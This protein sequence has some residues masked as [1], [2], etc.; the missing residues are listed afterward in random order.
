MYEDC[1]DD[2]TD[3]SEYDT[4]S[5]ANSE[6]RTQEV[7][8]AEVIG[9]WKR[10][11]ETRS[12]TNVGLVHEDDDL[13]A[14]ATMNCHQ[15]P[16]IETPDPS[17]MI[18]ATADTIRN[19][20]NASM[21][22]SSLLPH[23]TPPSPNPWASSHT[24]SASSLEDTT[25]STKRSSM[26][27]L[28][29]ISIDYIN[30]GKTF[31]E[32]SEVLTTLNKLLKKRSNYLT[33][34]TDSDGNKVGKVVCNG[35]G[36]MHL[37]DPIAVFSVYRKQMKLKSD[38]KRWRKFF[39]DSEYECC[40]TR[41]VYDN[42]SSSRIN[43]EEANCYESTLLNRVEHDYVSLKMSADEVDRIF[44]ASI[45][46]VSVYRQSL[47][48]FLRLPRP[49]GLKEWK[50][51]ASEI[52]DTL[53]K[54]KSGNSENCSYNLICKL[55]RQFHLI[56]CLPTIKASPFVPETQ[57]TIDHHRESIIISVRGTCQMLDAI[58]DV[59]ADVVPFLAHTVHGGH[60][61]AGFTASA[62]QLAKLVVPL[63][64]ESLLKCDVYSVL[65]TGHSMGGAVASLL[66]MLFHTD[67]I[68]I[69]ALVAE[70]V[71]IVNDQH[72]DRL[73]EKIMNQLR[74]SRCF[75]FGP[76]PCAT[77]SLCTAALTYITTIIVGKD[78]IPSLSVS[79]VNRLAQRLKDATLFQRRLSSTNNVED[80]QEFHAEQ[81]SDYQN[82]E[83]GPADDEVY[84]NGLYPH[85][86]NNDTE[87]TDNRPLRDM[88]DS[89]LVP[90]KILHVR[91][92]SSGSPSVF[93][94]QATYFSDIKLY[95]LSRSFSDHNLI[96]YVTL[97]RC[98]Y[99]RKTREA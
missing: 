61:H 52:K 74:S 6:H 14:D 54:T 29:S 90:G 80:A 68:D 78:M 34:D 60:T 98:L 65:V 10:V 9:E 84:G 4:Y 44:I 81:L 89:L 48:A 95:A 97:M 82:V 1:V 59:T 41:H 67:D 76:P 15:W 96:T 58:T 45:H 13:P 30:F 16:D 86:C 99:N 79:S 8:E 31:K 64:S 43:R 55:S 35:D 51:L 87:I 27:Y 32:G 47:T 42:C 77:L 24:P 21:T 66:T 85:S 69:K 46:S 28:P 33:D 53:S 40:G 72:D 93:P 22:V 37:L 3:R 83:E 71:R 18:Q 70:S 57:V 73:V 50:L 94:E 56:E 25:L 91:H 49:K 63:L 36:M 23:Q 12:P 5:G 20:I 7:D 19:I 39:M 26:S 38:I 92:I 2:D 88:N 62:W 11:Q 17:G 75:A